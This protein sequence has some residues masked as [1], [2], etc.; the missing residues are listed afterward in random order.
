[1]T[2]KMTKQSS[3]EIALRI[4]GTKLTPDKFMAGV[5][6]FFE[7][8]GEVSG[9]MQNKK[10]SSDLIVEA[11]TGSTVIAVRSPDQSLA[12]SFSTLASAI[13]DGLKQLE[14][15]DERP[16]Y[17]TDRTLE[18]VKALAKIRDP[19]YH[20]VEVVQIIVDH[21]PESLSSDMVAN[22]DSI[23]R[24]R[25]EAIGSIEGKLEVISGRKGFHCYVFDDLTDQQV[26]C[27]FN[28]KDEAIRQKIMSAFG[29]RVAVYG[30][31]KYRKD[32][33][34]A[35][36]YVDEIRVFRN[37]EDLPTLDQLQG[38]FKKK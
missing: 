2:K 5:K 10:L 34:P 22:V 19:K 20:T 29:K 30:T 18:A 12:E 4:D 15:N 1:M 14:E 17:F 9:Q 28:E 11:R 38:I 6:S 32:G 16:K 8:I 37:P 35:Y 13:H 25:H 7:I 27:R 3:Q 24:G 21:A 31:V 26:N 23:L 33:S 36:I